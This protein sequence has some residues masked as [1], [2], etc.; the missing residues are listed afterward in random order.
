MVKLQEN[1]MYAILSIFALLLFIVWC[2]VKANISLD[3][4]YIFSFSCSYT[5]DVMK[6]SVKIGN[7]MKSSESLRLTIDPQRQDNEISD[8]MINLILKNTL[9]W[10]FYPILW[11]IFASCWLVLIYS[12]SLVNS[13]VDVKVVSTWKKRQQNKRLFSHL[14]EKDTGFMQVREQK[15]Q[16]GWA[17]RN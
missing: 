5:S 2:H 8:N 9:N 16:S 17:N 3:S 10:F 13:I 7:R 11:L 14:S 4:I 1:Q 15:K 6:R 12:I